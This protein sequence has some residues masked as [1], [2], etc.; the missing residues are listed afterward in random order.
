TS[1]RVAEQTGDAR[2]SADGRYV[3]FASGATDLVDG[4]ADHNGAAPSLFRR[5]MTTGATTLVDGARGSA[6]DTAA[7]GSELRDFGADGSTVR[8][9]PRADYVAEEFTPSPDAHAPELYL[10]RAGAAEARLVSTRFNGTTAGTARDVLG[11]AAI[12]ADGRSVL[13][14]SDGWPLTD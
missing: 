12:S 8:S 1:A 4:F 13:F 14:T 10:R 11:P 7:E 6:S 5:D 2:M 3:S 9:A